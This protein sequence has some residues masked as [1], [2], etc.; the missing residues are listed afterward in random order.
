M[1]DLK[2]DFEDVQ[3]KHAELIVYAMVAKAVYYGD[4]K[5]LIQTA[6]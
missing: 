6:K 4:E 5:V 1:P 2:V 3:S